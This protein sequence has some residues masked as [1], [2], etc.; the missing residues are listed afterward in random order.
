MDLNFTIDESLTSINFTP[1]AQVPA[2]YGQPRVILGI[3][4]HHWGTF[5]QVFDEVTGFLCM[6]T[7][8]TSA[9]FVAMAGRVSCIVSPVDAAWHAGNPTGNATTIGI[10]CRP[11][12]SA[13]DF[14]TVA[15][16]V[17]W[18]RQTYGADLPLYR[19]S[20]WYN[21]ACCGIWDT[22]EVDR[23]AREIATG[24][25][26][27]APAGAAPLP[28]A[29]AAPAAPASTS[30]CIVESGDTLSSI[31]TQFGV[32]WAD[33]AS[34][35]GISAPYTISVGQVLNLPGAAIDRVT[36]CIVE[37]GDTLSGIAA[38]FSVGLQDLVAA[39]PGL[40]NPNLIH[41]GQVLNLPAAAPAAPAAP[42]PAPAAPAPVTQCV[43]EDGD[44]L[45]GIAVQFGT[46]LDRLIA[47]NP[48]INPDLIYPGQVLNL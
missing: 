36:Q 28:P 21:T 48:G 1:A 30:Q 47:A 19:H 8:P 39:N 2:V 20:D 23:R 41:A 15:Q 16:L 45:G 42:A 43:V 5:G 22:A 33:I 14:E 24:G 29:P 11:E 17:A 27:P 46:S 7:K 34:L 13:E 18:L 26:V 44:T 6:N 3:T 4:L 40:G 31:G 37:P 9:H 38:Q 25:T 12:R 10:E 32:A 35:N